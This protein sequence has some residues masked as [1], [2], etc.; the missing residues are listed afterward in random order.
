MDFTSTSIAHV[1]LTVTDIERS[2]QFY[3]SVFGWPVLLEVPDNADEATRNQLSFLFGGV[4]YDLGG[5]LLGLRPVAAGRF[6]ENRVGLDHIAFR[7]TT[8]DE[9]DSA[10]AH[11]D[12][13]GVTHEPI[14]DI[15][16]SY[17]LEFRDPD[18]IALELTAPK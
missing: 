2:R 17:I 4:I 8:R 9:L 13:L 7:L 6:D 18:N 11:L 5:T 14:K 1:R 16:P 15:G 10:A 3:E 12:D